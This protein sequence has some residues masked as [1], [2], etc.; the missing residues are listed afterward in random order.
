M[1]RDNVG[2]QGTKAA[3]NCERSFHEPE[4]LGVGPTPYQRLEAQRTL[5]IEAVEFTLKHYGHADRVREKLE[6]AL[7]TAQEAFDAKLGA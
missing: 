4:C 7:K 1:K 3:C 2:K 5:L 6:A